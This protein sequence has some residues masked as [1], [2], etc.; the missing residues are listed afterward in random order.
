MK[1]FFY[2]AFAVAASA[3]ILVEVVASARKEARLY[4]ETVTLSALA[5][6]ALVV[7]YQRRIT[8]SDFRVQSV[9]EATPLIEPM[10]PDDVRVL[11][12]QFSF[13]TD[14]ATGNLLLWIPKNQSEPFE[15][16]V[17]AI[18]EGRRV[19]GS[20]AML[21]AENMLAQVNV[22]GQADTADFPAVS[23]AWFNAKYRWEFDSPRQGYLSLTSGSD[24]TQQ[25]SYNLYP[26]RDGQWL[27]VLT[28][29]DSQRAYRLGIAGD[30][31]SF[32]H[33]RDDDKWFATLERDAG[34]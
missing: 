7:P 2:I 18:A 19:G 11:Y 12:R 5:G 21:G 26:S 17:R 9:I 1:K 25:F 20:A 22:E 3:M 30:S 27:I 31:L 16:T 10:L 24:P 34:R 29:P 32:G 4:P 6:T 14:S 8:D 15:F 13:F 28:A 33:L 23:G